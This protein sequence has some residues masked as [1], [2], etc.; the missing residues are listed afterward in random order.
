MAEREQDRLATIGGRMRAV[1]LARGMTAGDVAE[2][3]HVSRPT[4]TTWETDKVEKIDHDKLVDFAKLA[5]VSLKW[6]MA[7]VGKRPD[8]NLDINERA[9]VGK[10]RNGIA[11]A[12]VA[13]TG[14]PLHPTVEAMARLP[15]EEAWNVFK[16]MFNTDP[17]IL[18]LLS[19]LPTAGSVWPKADRKR[20]LQLLEGS[21]DLIYKEN[22]P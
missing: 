22:E 14:V 16:G 17:M 5:D 15:R 10:R 11:E 13:M 9:F 8:L 4:I 19:H 6:L 21:F 12:M 20:W 1:R 2:Q 3:L 18:G 7:G